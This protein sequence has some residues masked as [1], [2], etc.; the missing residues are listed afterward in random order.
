MIGNLSAGYRLAIPCYQLSTGYCLAIG[1][2]SAISRLA[3]IWLLAGHW[4]SIGWLSSGYWLA[5]GCQLAGHVLA[6]GWL[7]IGCWLA[8]GWLWAGYQ[9]TSFL[10]KWQLYLSTAVNFLSVSLNV[11]ILKQQTSHSNLVCSEPAC[12]YNVWA[13]VKGHN[14]SLL[15]CLRFPILIT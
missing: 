2:L 12:L 7:W 8:I 10:I 1:W 15:L 6:V 13:G 5:I 3:L 4:L 9:F 11:F 14:A